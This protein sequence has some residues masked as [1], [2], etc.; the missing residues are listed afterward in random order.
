MSEQIYEADE[1]G[2]LRRQI[3]LYQA[4]K[5]GVEIQLADLRRQLAAYKAFAA[6]VKSLDNWIYDEARLGTEVGPLED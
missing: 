5:E 3:K 1:M 6:T 2:I 4:M